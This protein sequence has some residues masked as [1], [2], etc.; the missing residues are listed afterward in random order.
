MLN[1]RE[2]ERTAQLRVAVTAIRMRGWEK[3]KK[4]KKRLGVEASEVEK[5]EGKHCWCVLCIIDRVR[6]G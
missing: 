3:G 2:D 4:V 5:V 6:E 1:T